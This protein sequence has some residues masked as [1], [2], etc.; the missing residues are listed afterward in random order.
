[1]TSS[2]PTRRAAFGLARSWSLGCALF[3]LACTACSP[4]VVELGKPDA[5]HDAASD[6]AATCRCRITPCRLASDCALTGGTCG[7]DFYC[8]GDFGPCTTTAQ[9]QATL[10]TSRCTLGTTSVLSCP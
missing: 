7:A 8:T 3:A 4:R 9:C 6:A 1:M 10:A 2:P 5:A